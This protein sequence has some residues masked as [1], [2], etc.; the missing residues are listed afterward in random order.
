[1][2]RIGELD[3]IRGIAIMLVVLCHTLTCQI[4]WS[5]FLPSDNTVRLLML[6]WTGVDLFFILSGFLIV[7][8]L[9]DEK[10]RPH[11]FRSFYVRRVCR[12]LPLYYLVI[13]SYLLLA[14]SGWIDSHWLFGDLLPEFSYLTFTQNFFMHD[15]GWGAFGLAP[16]WSVAVEEQFYLLIP[17]LVHRLGRKPL[18]VLFVLA[19]L[20]APVTRYLTGNLGAYTFPHARTDAIL[21]GGLM[22]MLYRW[23]AG[24]KLVK[25]N[26][27]R[28]VWLMLL[29][30][31]ALWPLMSVEAGM[32]DKFLHVVLAVG[33]GLLVLVALTR[34]FPW[35][36]RFLQNR[37]LVWLGMRSY[38]IY[39]FHEP[40]GGVVRALVAPSPD[41]SFETWTDVWVTALIYGLVALLSELS[42]RFFEGPILR[43][44]HRYARKVRE[45]GAG[46]REEGI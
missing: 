30:A 21:L 29:P 23:P 6:G 26:A 45:G 37:F 41:P 31:L 4:P 7:G 24:W 36:G 12:I 13:V 39:L 9:M 5:A 16:T 42:F 38:A 46:P 19:I 20:Q 2:K 44:G 33:Y 15:A 40:V 27:R 14:R 17:L 10:G 32:G 25:D 22:A 43:L 28:W 34:Q 18:A 11:Y 1:M 35:L 3:G 8:I